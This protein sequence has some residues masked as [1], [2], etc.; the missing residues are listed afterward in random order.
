MPPLTNDAKS[1]RFSKPKTGNVVV[2]SLPIRPKP[3]VEEIGD[4]DMR[5]RKVERTEPLSPSGTS[6]DD[7]SLKPPFSE[8]DILYCRR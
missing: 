1:R 5:E 7:D 6:L 3:G 8:L 2:I 4:E